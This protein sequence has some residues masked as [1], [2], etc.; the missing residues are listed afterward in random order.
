[1]WAAGD[2]IFLVPLLLLTLTWFRAE[3]EKG[4]LHDEKLDRERARLAQA[5]DGGS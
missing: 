3:E 2:L 5:A 4:R 1:M